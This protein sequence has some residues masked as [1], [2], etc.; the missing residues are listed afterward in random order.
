MLG[1]TRAMDVDV[2]REVVA[3]A[4]AHAAELVSDGSCPEAVTMTNVALGAHTYDLSLKSVGDRQSA[5][6]EP[7]HDTYIEEKSPD[8]TNP[9]HG[10]VHVENDPGNAQHALLRFDTASISTTRVVQSATLWLYVHTEDDSRA[11][12]VHENT[13]G[14]D[15]NTANWNNHGT[16]YDTTAVASVAP[17][18][19][20]AHWLAIPLTATVQR[21]INNP[22]SNFGIRLL[23]TSDAV[24]SKY[25]SKEHGTAANRPYLDV[26]HVDAAAH[27]AVATI[28]AQLASGYASGPILQPLDMFQ[29]EQTAFIQPSVEAADA[30]FDTGNNGNAS[31]LRVSASPVRMSALRFDID[32]IPLGATVTSATL[33]LY[34]DDLANH[35]SIRAEAFT[36]LWT[37]GQITRNQAR[38]FDPWAR[39]NGEVDSARGHRA[40]TVDKNNWLHIDLSETVQRWVNGEPNYG[41]RLST[42]DADVSF[43]SSDDNNNQ[44]RWKLTVTYACACGTVC[45][46]GVTTSANSAG[47]L[48]FIVDSALSISTE[49]RIRYELFQR[50]GYDVTLVTDTTFDFLPGTYLANKDVVYVSAGARSASMGDLRNTSVGVVNEHPNA[51]DEIRI[52]DGSTGQA[53]VALSIDTV[54]HPI[55]SALSLADATLSSSAISL[56][57][58]NNPAAGAEVLGSIGGRP[59]LLA[60][61]AGNEDSSGGSAAGNRVALPFGPNTRWRN[62]NSTSQMLVHSAL[63]WA[64]DGTMIENYCNADFA[65]NTI[66]REI[67]PNTPQLDDVAWVPEGAEIDGVKAPVGGAWLVTDRANARLRLVADDGSLLAQVDTPTDDPAGASYVADGKHAGN[68]VYVEWFD[69]R[70]VFME[71]DGSS[72][73]RYDTADN[74]MIS[75]TGVSYIG[76]TL[77]GVYDDHVAVVDEWTGYVTFYDQDG[78]A[79]NQITVVAP[80]EPEGIVH[81]PGSDKLLI[82]YPSSRRI[83]DTSGNLIRE[84]TAGQPGQATGIAIHGETCQHVLSDRATGALKWLEQLPQPSARWQFNEAGGSTTTDE[85]AGRVGTLKDANWMA[86]G[87]NGSA[88]EFAGGDSGVTVSADA[89]LALE[90]DFSLSAW[91]YPRN[92][93]DFQAV[94]SNDSYFRLA[95]KGNEL[96]FSQTGTNTQDIISTGALITADEWSYV[97]ATVST[98]G[99]VSLYSNNVLVGTGTL[100]EAPSA[101]ASEILLGRDHE[102]NAFSGVID[103]VRIYDELIDAG[104]IGKEYDISLPASGS[105]PYCAIASDDFESGDWGGSTGSLAWSGDWEEVNEDGNPR[106]GDEVVGQPGQTLVARLR[107]NDGGGEGIERT[108][109]LSGFGTATLNFEY[110]RSALESNDYVMVLYSNDGGDSWR[111]LQRIQGSGTDPIDSAGIE[112]SLTLPT[113]ITDKTVVRFLTWSGMGGNDRVYIDNLSITACP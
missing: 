43:V 11:I 19:S 102:D 45:N 6:F 9:S 74:D 3:A 65:P 110:W 76:T 96:L 60:L 14:F 26:V 41:I 73:A 24:E 12:S 16:A 79:Q 103:D 38:S 108:V 29:A 77:S 44:R 70:L 93:T 31:E 56:V 30:W 37:E 5:V 59:A 85:V 20:N 104:T 72:I 50:W 82:T 54:A 112:S 10:D 83:I 4:L 98:D 100:S 62:L 33:S 15:E 1:Q 32:A 87:V 86:T 61:P 92:V 63:K 8:K 75:T 84:Y 80:E 57:T 27:S 68:W 113:P 51:M 107:D 89:T 47:N 36:A 55:T 64:A 53:A 97:V 35:G 13:S 46:S 69:E 17:T 106:N 34:T 111:E 39:T 28:E 67:D 40:I 42:S 22:G 21:W 49:E 105:N 95:L 7:I 18:A 91:V 23:A 94:M 71:P 2:S 25:T 109:D 58:L 88:L 99:E 101:T 78:V 48:L 90:R 52:A 66:E 81:L